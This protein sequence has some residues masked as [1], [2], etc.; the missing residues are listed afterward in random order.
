VAHENAWALHLLGKA[1]LVRFLDGQGWQI[2]DAGK[3][4]LA[5]GVCDEEIVEIVREARRKKTVAVEDPIVGL[6]ELPVPPRG[7]SDDPTP[8]VYAVQGVFG[9]PVKL[10][11]TTL[12]R[13]F[14][15]TDENDSRGEPLRITRLFAG[16]RP[17]ERALHQHFE[18]LR[19]RS[20]REW[21]RAAPELARLVYAIPEPTRTQKTA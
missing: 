15:R 5:E 8:C 11:R 17:T 4:L 21:F 12:G 20:N 14:E 13:L 19:L 3:R 18:H 7:A 2:T 10:G 1:L 9:G 6:R 16:G